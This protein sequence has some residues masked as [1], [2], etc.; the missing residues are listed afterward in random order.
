MI[1][2][3][4]N[5]D[6]P[7]ATPPRCP[8]CSRP[9]LVQTVISHTSEIRHEGRLHTIEVSK[10]PVLKCA[11]CGEILFTNDSDRAITQ[12]LRAELGLLAPETI[13]Q[14]RARI[15]LK[16]RELADHLGVAVETISRWET[17]L[18]IQSRAMN[19]LLRLYFEVPEARIALTAG[20]KNSA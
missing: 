3:S 18:L 9:A 15:G 1:L 11:K 10:L 2:K 8:S 7:A 13:R 5:C 4:T 12:A 14:A 20:L 16:Q 6:V 17:G 19:N